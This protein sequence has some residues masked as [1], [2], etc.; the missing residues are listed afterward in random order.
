M[1][2]KA[3]YYSNYVIHFYFHLV[4]K[5]FIVVALYDSNTIILI[6]CLITLPQIQ[7]LI[8]ICFFIFLIC[9]I[10]NLLMSYFHL[11]INN[12][13]PHFMIFYFFSFQ[14]ETHLNFLLFHHSNQIHFL[15][16][17]PLLHFHFLHHF[18]FHY[19]NSLHL[20]L[21]HFQIK[22]LYN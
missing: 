21:L 14:L 1:Q 6:L 11:L 16:L 8:L 10:H 15:P 3:I 22:K 18:N 2:F 9:K 5:S 4:I 7:I 12:S 19:L 20:I 13:I 17:L